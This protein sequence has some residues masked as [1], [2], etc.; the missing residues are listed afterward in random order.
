M[1]SVATDWKVTMDVRKIASPAGVWTIMIVASFVWIV[2]A[3]INCTR[4]INGDTLQ[5]CRSKPE[6]YSLFPNAVLY[7]IELLDV[8][9][10]LQL[11]ILAVLDLLLV[12]ALFS[13]RVLRRTSV[14]GSLISLL[15]FVVVS[16]AFG[17]AM[18]IIYLDP[19]ILS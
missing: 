13:I 8:G 6:A 2:V 7:H 1:E 12:C 10:R 14:A 19:T 4:A 17:L 9:R 11:L 16:A 15:V 5:A 18:V 3:D